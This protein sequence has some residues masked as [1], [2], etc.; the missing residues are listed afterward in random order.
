MDKVLIKLQ[1][2][3]QEPFWIAVCERIED[4]KLSACKIIFGA[5]PKGYEVEE[6]VLRNWYHLRF[7]PTT[8]VIVKQKDKVNPKRLQR[9]IKK[10]VSEA[11]IGT[12]SQ[13]ALKLLQ[14]EN[15][16]ERKVR[17]RRQ[18]E[19]EQER[20]FALRQQKKREKHRGR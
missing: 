7:S 16:L 9:E 20:L 19:E 18:M 2:F 15:K 3:F 10:Q 5:E 8:D 14:E 13:Q 12:K 11:G 6:Y 17:S 4:T 1:V